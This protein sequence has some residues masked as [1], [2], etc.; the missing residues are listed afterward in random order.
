M[1][2]GRSLFFLAACLLPAADDVPVYRDPHQLIEARVKDLVGRMT[3]EEKLGQLNI[4]AAYGGI[5]AKRVPTFTENEAE[6][7]ARREACRKFTLGT[8]PNPNLRR[9]GPGGGFFDLTDRVLP[10]PPREMASFTNELQRV[11]RQT[12]LG[13]PLLEIEEGTHGFMCSSGTIFPEG[14][15]LGSTWNP[16]LVREVY[17]TAIREARAVG[18]HALCTLVIE[19]DID[20]RMGRN[21]EG[22]SEDPYICSRYAEAIVQ[23]IQGTDVSAADKGIASLCHFPGQSQGFAGLEYG[24]MMM[25]ERAFRNIFLPPWEA[26]I[27][28]AGAL[29]VMATHPVYDIYGGLPVHASKRILTNLLRDELHFRGAVLGE[30]ASVG[31]ILWKKVAETQKEA[32]RMGINAGLDV[33]ISL[34]PGFMADMYDSVTEGS[35]AM[36]VVDQAVARVL[37]LKFMLGLFDR[38]FVDE[39]A[40]DKTLH[41]EAARQ[42]ALRAAREGIVL[43]KN[44]NSLLPLSK[45]VKSMAV[46][47]PLA[48]AP[49]D[50]LGDYHPAHMK[51]TVV[52]PLAGLKAKLPGAKITYVKG[53]EVLN[54]KFDQ[55]QDAVRAAKAAEVA[56]VFVGETGGTAGEK[57]DS[58]TLELLGRQNE[59]IQAVQSTGTPTVVV[60][61]NGRP[62]AINWVAEHVPAILDAWFIGEQGGNAVADVLLGDYNPSGRLPVSVPRHAGQLPAYY[63][64]KPAKEQRRNGARKGFAYVDLPMEPL[65][66]FGY[67]LSYTSFAYSNLKISPERPGPGSD[68]TVSCDVSN[69]GKMAGDETV[70]LYL[71]D[72]ITSVSSPIR[73]LKGFRKVHLNPGES[74]RVTMMMRPYDL[75]LLDANLQRVVEPGVFEVMIGKS[76]E[77]IQLRG[78]FTVV[79]NPGAAAGK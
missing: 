26:G 36:E 24:D 61:L 31:T 3:L 22:Y 10:V 55:I 37:R 16:E 66:D 2:C 49:L 38:P 78:R 68:V 20:P 76:C 45:R 63:F 32:G 12:R 62:L 4:P 9:L 35:V 70:E 7:A 74:R 19:P 15:A 59:L 21:A 52:T 1:N 27:R 56:V 23:G 29:L 72:L 30:G 13:I 77:D 50:Q 8:L 14:H 58:A 71:H 11:A 75:S 65:Y 53:V 33:S 40:A 42:L 18:I 51:Q 44:E 67:G 41:N 57:R 48:D 47:G 17:A 69:T 54:P 73:Q 34:E 6:L 64:Y 43:L 5:E 39:G 79:Q 60:V 28:E 25:S 46:I